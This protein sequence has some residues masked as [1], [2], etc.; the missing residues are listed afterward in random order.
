MHQR[1]QYYYLIISLMFF[2]TLLYMQNMFGDDN[3]KYTDQTVYNVYVDAP[4]FTVNL[5][6]NPTTGYKWYLEE[7]D[8]TLI[9][10][11]NSEYKSNQTKNKNNSKQ[12]LVGV[13]GI[14]SWTF[15]VNSSAFNV[16]RI[17]EISFVYI[18]PWAE[19][20]SDKNSDKKLGDYDIEI[21][22][23]INPDK[24]PKSLDITDNT[25]DIKPTENKAE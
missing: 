19:G 24:K 16:P 4:E 21:K 12:P 15:K 7:L 13:G 22:V 9:T 18:R 11:V 20:G 5:K 8:D 1:N 10:A 14:Q 6:S 2:S 23:I 3:S 25:T 17:S